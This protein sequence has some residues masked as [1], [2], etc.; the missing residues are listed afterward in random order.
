[1]LTMKDFCS[2]CPRACR[3]DRQTSV[4]FCAEHEK[5]RIAKVVEHFKWEEPCLSDDRG[6]LA[7]FFSGCNLKCEYCQNHEISRGGV[8]EEYSVEQFVNLVEEKQDSHSAID[9]ITPTHFSKELSIAF[10]KI[11]KHVPVIWNT[12]GYETVENIRHIS[13]FVDIFL[14]DF[15]YSSDALGQKF[16]K[17]KDYFSNALPAIQEMCLQKSDQYSEDLT[18]KRGVIIRHLVLPGYVKNSLDTLD[19]ISKYF[20]DRTISLMSQFTPNGYGSLNRKITPLEYKLVLTHFQNLGLSKG[21]F[22]DYS[23]A[24][25]VFVPDFATI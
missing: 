7:I 14:P 23:S 2:I 3:I 21:Y 10:S 18:M 11:R 9:L 20:P 6:V 25:K 13:E 17:C 4:G 1:M 24:D 5:I 8:G 12:N 22:Q 15:K 19:I 16:S